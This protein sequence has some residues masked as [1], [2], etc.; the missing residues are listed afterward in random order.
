MRI[1][2]FNNPEMLIDRAIASVFAQTYERIE[3]V[4]VGDACTDDTEQ[5]IATLREPRIRFVNLTSAKPLPR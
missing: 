4:V 5:R 3:V 1:T 2:T